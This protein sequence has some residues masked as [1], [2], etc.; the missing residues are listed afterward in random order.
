MSDFQQYLLPSGRGIR[1]KELSSSAKD[2]VTK[3]AAKLA[4]KDAS[5]ID[6]RMCELH[7]GVVAM[8]DSVTVDKFPTNESIISADVKWKNVNPGELADNYDKYFSAKDDTVLSNIYRKLHEVTVDEL[9]AI[10]L[11]VLTVSKD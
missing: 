2:R 7:E 11:K 9:E 6:F 5:V 8:L 4:G 3:N 10:S 1:V